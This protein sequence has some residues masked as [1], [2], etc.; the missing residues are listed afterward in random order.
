MGEILLAGKE[1]QE[2]PALLR[3]VIAD[4]PLQR[5][6]ARLERVQDRPLGGLTLDLDRYF[7]VHARKRP[8]VC[9]KFN[10]DH[11]NVWTSTETTAGKSRAM[12]AQ[13]SPASV[14]AYTCPPVVPKYTPH[15]SS[16]STA[17]ASRNTFT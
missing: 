5:G 9:R 10:A 1:P 8:Q 2:W 16:E 6:I 11:G 3:D 4:C 13:L 15:E 7:T 17:I 14:D 12:G